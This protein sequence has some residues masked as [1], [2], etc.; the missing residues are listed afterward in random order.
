M[1]Y[2]KIDKTLTS[3][4]FHKLQVFFVVYISQSLELEEIKKLG[5]V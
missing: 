5:L 1:Y 4:T 3:Y 2:F